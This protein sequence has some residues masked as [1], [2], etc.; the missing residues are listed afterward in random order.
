[1]HDLA[2]SLDTTMDRH[3]SGGEDDAALFFVE[4]GPDYQIGDAGFVLDGNE[5]DAF[6]RARL[7]PHQHQPGGLQP[8]AVTCLH[9]L[10]TSD[11]ALTS[12]FR[13]EEADGMAAQGRPTWL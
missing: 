4:A 1:M 7:L 3:H 11:K 10:G 2:F 6:G 5:Q 12:Q 8:T 9:R 13:A